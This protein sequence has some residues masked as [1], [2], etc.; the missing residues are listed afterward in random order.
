MT[1][2]AV[3]DGTVS[4]PAEA[5][6]AGIDVA[7]VAATQPPKAIRSVAMIPTTARP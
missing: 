7:S 5:P 6:A 1:L 3:D 4:Y 2:G